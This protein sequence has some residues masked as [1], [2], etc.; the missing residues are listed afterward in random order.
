M[1]SGKS[2]KLQSCQQIT[3]KTPEYVRYDNNYA[4]PLI[5]IEPFYELPKDRMKIFMKEAPENYNDNTFLK[6]N[7]IPK[8]YIQ[9]P[10][11]G[12]RFQD[13]QGKFCRIKDEFTEK[14]IKLENFEI[15]EI[16]AFSIGDGLFN[17]GFSIKGTV[18]VIYLTDISKNQF[19][20][21]YSEEV[22]KTNGKKIKSIEIFTSQIGKFCEKESDITIYA[23]RLIYKDKSK[24]SKIGFTIFKKVKKYTYTINDNRQLAYISTCYDET[25]IHGINFISG[26]K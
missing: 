15:E 14:L 21:E 18:E 1:S 25:V 24:S 9:S 6:I 19:Y 8:F 11:Y 12:Y 5:I 22:I 26:I 3:K 4:G 17:I 20:S 13:E 23:L 10:D 7:S 2:E 16:R